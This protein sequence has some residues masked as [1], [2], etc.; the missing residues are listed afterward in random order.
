MPRYRT[1]SCH[2]CG[3]MQLKRDAEC[4]KCGRMTPRER[5]RWTAKGIQLLVMGAVILYGYY[6]IKSLFPH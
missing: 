1:I 6:Q 5:D 4:E 3:Y 2:H